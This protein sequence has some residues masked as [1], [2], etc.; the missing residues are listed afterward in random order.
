MSRAS[1]ICLLGGIFDRLQLQT[2]QEL[3]KRL[4]ELLPTTSRD[5]SKRA[6]IL[7]KQ[8]EATDAVIFAGFPRQC[9]F[10]D[11]ILTALLS[12]CNHSKHC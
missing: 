10:Y 3:S 5:K 9:G 4:A 12:T 11:A 6:T 2:A 1:L 7:T 8:S